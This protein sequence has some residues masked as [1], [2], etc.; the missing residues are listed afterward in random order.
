MAVTEFGTG[1]PQAAKRW[2]DQL[3]RETLGKTYCSRFMG[4]GSDAII[5]MLPDLESAPGDNIKYDLRVQDRSN[6]VQGDTK[7]KGF[8]SSLVFHQD[9]INID[10]LR[11][12]HAFRGMTQQRTV[13][14][15]RAEG[16]ASLSDWFAWVYDSMT[17]AYATGVAGDSNE[18]VSGILGVGG[19]AGNALTAPDADHTF[20]GSTGFVVGDLDDAVAM[21]KVTNPRVRPTKVGGQDKYVAV[22]H[23][24]SI[25][26]MRIDAGASGWNQI[27]QNASARAGS[28]PI[29][30]G[31]LG[32]YNGV[33]IHESEFI[34]RV[35]NT[36]YNVFLGAGA[37]T[38]AFGNAWKKS[39]RSAGGG[40]SYFSYHEETED[41]DNEE[42]IA[43]A[44]CF[45]IKKSTFN[46]ADFGVIR[47]DNTETGP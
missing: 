2:S 35:G 32:E 12:A 10:Q 14:D 25:R 45:G 17:F 40:G 38:C 22:L 42:G 30:T 15:L 47:I 6:G 29:Y 16:R 4:K 27:H 3:F 21:A 5:R 24:Y 36:T 41:Y 33:V 1:D 20:V 9:E 28:N 26:S 31:A 34:P 43:A 23:P 7:L 18:S 13:H 19:F 46:S 8:E 39:R 37:L 11:Q 44:S